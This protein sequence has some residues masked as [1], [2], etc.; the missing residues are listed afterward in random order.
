MDVCGEGRCSVCTGGTDNVG[1][2]CE[3]FPKELSLNQLCRM[4]GFR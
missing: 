3:E 4:I 2:V 1:M